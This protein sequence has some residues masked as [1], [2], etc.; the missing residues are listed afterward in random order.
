MIG[1]DSPGPHASLI[2]ALLVLLPR[3]PP[4]PPSPRLSAGPRLGRR[5]AIDD[6]GWR[7]CS[8]NAPAALHGPPAAA[9]A[10]GLDAHHAACPAH[11]IGGR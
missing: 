4:S 8:R 5:G 3:F 11:R 1:H 7:S 10:F 2:P 6:G 9:L